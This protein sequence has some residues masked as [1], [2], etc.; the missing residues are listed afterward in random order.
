MTTNWLSR[1]EFVLETINGSSRHGMDIQTADWNLEMN[2]LAYVVGLGCCPSTELL[3]LI[4]FSRN[5]IVIMIEWLDIP[6]SE[7]WLERMGVFQLLTEKKM[8]KNGVQL[9][10]VP[11]VPYRDCCYR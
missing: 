8:K 9:S 7:K 5:L 2:R 4:E 11:P 6:I 3:F 10:E 1:K